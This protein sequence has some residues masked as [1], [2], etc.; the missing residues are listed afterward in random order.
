MSETLLALPRFFALKSKSNGKYLK[1]VT[2]GP[3]RGCLQ[4][5]EDRLMSPYAKFESVEYSQSYK[6]G[7]DQLCHVRCCYN[8]KYWVKSSGSDGWISGGADAS[9]DNK[10]KPTCTLFKPEFL[11]KEGKTVRI[12]S[13]D[14]HTDPEAVTEVIPN[15]DGSISLR[16]VESKGDM[17]ELWVYGG[18]EPLWI[19]NH[20]SSGTS[21]SARPTTFQAVKLEGNFIALKSNSCGKYCKELTASKAHN[22]LAAATDN[23]GD[24]WGHLTVEEPIDKRTIDDFDYHKDDARIDKHIMKKVPLPSHTNHTHKSTTTWN[25]TTTRV[26]SSDFHV[27]F[28]VAKELP[29][30]AKLGIDYRELHKL[31]DSVKWGATNEYFEESGDGVDYEVPPMT[32]VTAYE[33]TTMETIDVPFSYKQTDRLRD[34]TLVTKTMHDGL[35][36]Y[37]TIITDTE[38][39]EKKITDTESSE[40][41]IVG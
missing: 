26:S 24:S 30:Q 16:S 18:D 36:T 35:Y 25:R 15:P 14:D 39:H 41:T 21:S 28:E 11:D 10:S 38:T 3:Q 1:Y 31:T 7:E 22:C 34:G 12:F 9:E 13:G 37:E 19:I 17:W 20:R 29:F 6:S 32:K 8:N 40:E 33:T 23:I 27:N 4:F 2:Q 5:S